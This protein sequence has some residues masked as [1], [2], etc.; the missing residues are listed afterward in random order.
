MMF[1]GGRMSVDYI[2]LQAGLQPGGLAARD[3]TSGQDW[4]FRQFDE[5]TSRMAG[6]LRAHGVGAGDRVALLAKNR[7]SQVL[8][9][10]ACARL[11]AIFVPLNWRLSRL[12][13][14]TQLADA[15]PAMLLGDSQLESVGLDGISLDAFEAA[16][17]KSEPLPAQFYDQK[18]TSLILYTSGTSGKPKGVM[19]SEA[20]L[21][22]TGVNFSVLARVGPC[23]AVLC[24]APMFHVIGLVGNIRPTLMVGG[25]ILVSDGFN[26]ARTLARLADPALAVTHYFCVPQ[27]AA[28]LRHDPSYNPAALRHLT[29]I[30]SGGA[31]HAPD[32]IRALTRNGIPLAN[33]Y[34][35]TEAS[36]TVCCM[37]VDI[38]EIEENIGASGL[39]PPDVRVRIVDDEEN[40][41]PLG[42][43]GEILVKG[44]N[45]SA[46]YW[47]RPVETAA[48]F[49]PDHWYRSGDIGFLDARGYL[50]VIDR[51]KDMFISG[52]ENIYPAEIEAALA[53]FPGLA[54]CAVIGVADERWGE[55]GHLYAVALPGEQITPPALIE[56]LESRLARYKIPKHLTLL[57]ALPRNGAGKLVKSVL[58][59]DV[60]RV[61]GG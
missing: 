50:S 39:M 33:G 35:M 32:A 27:M 40:D 28:S 22:A 7:V 18:K 31:P 49:T 34:G 14:D 43:S 24:D 51:K 23:S 61:I 47:R 5:D 15:E 60:A 46:G 6:V 16:A 38:G 58:R 42:Q 52:G 55:V 41:V 9:H 19:L 25:T 26:P 12:E 30:F 1:R 20:N 57:E 4:S 21:W 8:L 45:V 17:A 29:G 56:F 48:A 3:L 2:A 11:E 13:L 10:L 59:A 54:E 36:G 44:E 37:P 53:D